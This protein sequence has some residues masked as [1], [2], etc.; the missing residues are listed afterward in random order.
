MRAFLFTIEMECKIIDASPMIIID[1]I[2]SHLHFQ[3]ALPALP[4]YLAY[5]LRQVHQR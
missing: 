3:G 4:R 5:L 1:F 2:M